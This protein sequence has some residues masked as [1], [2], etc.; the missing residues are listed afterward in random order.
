VVVHGL[1]A[2]L[3]SVAVTG[4]AGAAVYDGAKRFARTMA[5]S[6][7]LR[8]A[9]VTVT[10]VGLRGARVAEAGAERARLA[11]GDIVSE[12]RERIGE[13]TRPPGPAT[14]AHEHEH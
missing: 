2:K 9:A 5:D 4:V 10:A 8:R 11:A 1:A 14:P 7:V 6:R 12:A 13:Q 3:V